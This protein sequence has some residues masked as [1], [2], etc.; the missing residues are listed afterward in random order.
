[1]YRK[2]S[3]KAFNSEKFRRLSFFPY[4]VQSYGSS[5]M[6]LSA[7]MVTLDFP[8]SVDVTPVSTGT[9]AVTDIFIEPLSGFVSVR[10]GEDKAG[11]AFRNT[12]RASAE[13]SFVV[14]SC[15]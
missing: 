6:V 11:A 5:F 3:A 8:R 1:M 14:L 12:E 9:E 2:R 15:S 13:S 4:D 7:W 10:D